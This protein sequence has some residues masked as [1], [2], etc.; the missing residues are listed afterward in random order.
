[1]SKAP[2][3]A[4]A[5]G[6]LAGLA[7]AA[8]LAKFGF[9]AEVFEAAPNLGEIG[10]GVNVSPQAIRALRAIGLGENIAAAANIAPGVLT[11]DMHSGASLD[12]RDHADVARRFGAPV[13]SF[14]R[15]DLLDALARGVDRRRLHLGHRL[16][17]IAE[18]AASV[19]L[20]FANGVTHDAELV[21]AADGIHSQVRRA[22]YGDDHP[23]YTGQMV[24]RALLAGASLPADALEPS[25]HV[26]WLGSGRHFFAYYLR[27][28]DVVNLVTQQDTARWVEEGWSIP[29]DVA[30]MRAS[31]PNPEPRLKALLDA[32]TR[33]SQWG[34]FTRP[35]TGNWGRGRIQLIGDAAHAML[36]NAGQGAAQSFEDAYILA[37]WL[38]ALPADPMTAMENFRRVRI[39]RVHAVQRSSSTIVRTKHDYNPRGPDVARAKVDGVDAMAWIWDYDVVAAW[40][41][42]PTMPAVA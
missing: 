25:G 26:Q 16:I 41:Q 10:A 12:Y 18:R 7:A 42:P 37:R 2:R 19:E 17:A 36:P 27:G 14:H 13:C 3:V 28:R 40:D 30:E 39:P 24:W 4:I 23:A 35:L 29:G 8:A 20:R 6:G 22:L 34:L 32:V 9:A 11:R 21:I 38:A 33:C 31:F 5:G 1:M 15:A